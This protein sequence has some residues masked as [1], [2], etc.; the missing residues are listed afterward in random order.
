[1]T[2]ASYD[3]VVSGGGVAGLTAA[4]VFGSAGFS[5]LCVDP[6]PP[7][8]AR[9][10]AGSD[11]RTTAFLQPAQAL[12]DRAGLW[13]RLA[14]HA[15]DLQVMRIVD[16]G[17]ELPEPRVVREFN[18]SDISERP[19][20]WNL[21]NW[22][23][24]REMV[25]HLESLPSVTFKPGTG[26]ATL[27]TREAEARVGLSDGT[28]VRCRLVIAADGRGSP[29]REAAGIHVKTTRYGQKALAFAVTH[30][31]PHDNV[32]TEIHRSGG[33][34]T[35]VP[36][37]D[38]DGRPSSAIV[39]MEEGPEVARLAALPEPEF[40]AA[41][42]VR[43]CHLFGPLTLAS[44]RTVWPIISQVAERM[45]GERV[46]LVAEAAHVVPPIGAQGLNMS[47]GDMRVLL[48]LAEANPE[49]LGDRTM[50]DTYHRRRHFE[51]QARVT[52]IDLLNRASMLSTQ[53]LRDARAQALSAIYSLAPVR[54]TL[55]QMGLGARG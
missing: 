26:T 11:L 34:F 8:T 48:E 29:I 55:M 30:P 9:D 32:S 3:I 21:P 5:V 50:L 42:N 2:Q 25:A 22:L 46:A 27:F 28:R 51:V 36:L 20:G 23:L 54:K 12:L 4:A 49:A 37:P 45:S 14:P 13:A 6:A 53:P 10:A 43:S 41:M 47:L 17:G 7:V 39:W 40:E 35:L 33:P 15:T 44:R 1:M 19:F 16:A 18:A 38:H 31:I 52:G 24:R